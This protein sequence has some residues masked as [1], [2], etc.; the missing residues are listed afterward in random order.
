MSAFQKGKSMESMA[1][2][3]RF[4]QPE[5]DIET[6]I[7]CNRVAHWYN[8]RRQLPADGSATGQES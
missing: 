1:V 2:S 5:Y 4:M 3:R 8:E 6:G 7:D